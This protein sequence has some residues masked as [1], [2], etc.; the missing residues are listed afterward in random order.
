MRDFDR[1]FIKYN[2]LLSMGG[3][4]RLTYFPAMPSLIP[5]SFFLDN[6]TVGLNHR[7]LQLNITKSENGGIL[8]RWVGFPWYTYSTRFRLCSPSRDYFQ[9][10]DTIFLKPTHEINI[11]NMIDCERWSNCLHSSLH[12]HSGSGLS[13]Q[14]A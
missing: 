10:H 11:S 7:I 14:Y 4:S 1:P 12:F 5:E 6:I 13:I 3:V 8:Y 9:L 2:L